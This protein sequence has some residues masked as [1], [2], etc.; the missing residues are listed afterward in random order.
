MLDLS[1]AESDCSVDGYTNL[2]STIHLNGHNHNTIITPQSP[3]HLHQ[4]MQTT[5]MKTHLL[6]LVLDRLS[7][8]KQHFLWL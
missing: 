6:L 3:A 4:L 5:T 7:L 1:S 8:M 2:L